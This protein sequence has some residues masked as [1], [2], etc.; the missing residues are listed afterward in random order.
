MHWIWILSWDFQIA[1]QQEELPAA[2]LKERNKNKADHLSVEGRHR[3]YCNSEP[4]F[5][6]FFPNMSFPG[7]TEA[8]LS[9]PKAVFPAAGW[10]LP[11]Q[12]WK[13]ANCSQVKSARGHLASHG[14]PVAAQLSRGSSRDSGIRAGFELSS[15]KG[16][17]Q[18]H[19]KGANCPWVHGSDLWQGMLSLLSTS[20]KP[21]EKN[22]LLMPGLFNNQ[23]SHWNAL[24][25][26][27][28]S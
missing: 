11:S 8:L 27:T 28:Y 6:G 10:S 15:A 19:G 24:L 21:S 1:L 22:L 4:L 20:T 2:I 9:I 13:L 7:L 3:N 17:R 26:S 12:H 5:V 16:W 18:L 23:G 25:S 14:F